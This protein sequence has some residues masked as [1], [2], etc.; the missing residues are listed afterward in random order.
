[1]LALLIAFPVLASPVGGRRAFLQASFPLL[2]AGLT[3]LTLVVFA[4]MIE[5]YSFGGSARAAGE[6]SVER[7]A[8]LAEAGLRERP[9]VADQH[10]H[11][12]KP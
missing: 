1:M 5:P 12:R 3:I 6:A 11:D 2:G 7:Q 8:Q 10:P 4:R 9:P